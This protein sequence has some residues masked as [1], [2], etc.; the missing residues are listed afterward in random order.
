[1]AAVSSLLA[2]ILDDNNAPIHKLVDKGEVRKLF[3]TEN[4]QPW[5][6]QLMTTPQT[7]AWFYMLNYWLEK[8]KVEIDI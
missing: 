3:N 5:Y 2:P 8:Y 6:G 4:P 7:V 1:M